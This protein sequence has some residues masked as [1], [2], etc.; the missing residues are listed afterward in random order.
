MRIEGFE[1]PRGKLTIVIGPTA[2]GKS[3]LVNAIMGEALVSADSAKVYRRG[4]IGFVPQEAWIMNAT[5]RDN[6]LMGKEHDA[7]A[8]KAAVVACQ[9]KSDL[10][11]L[12]GSDQTE[13][14]E[15]GINL[16]GGQKQRVAFARAVYSDSDIVIMDD[17]LSA[18]DPHVCGALF[19]ACIRTALAGKTRVLV[20]HQQ[21]FLEWADQVVVVAERRVVFRG[22]Y[23]DLQRDEA[24]QDYVAASA[25]AQPT[26]EELPQRSTSQ[27]RR[28]STARMKRR[29][30]ATMGAHEATLETSESGSLFPPAIDVDEL[31][32]VLTHMDSHTK[33]PKSDRTPHRHGGSSTQ[34]GFPP[35]LSP[36]VVSTIGVTPS[37]LDL[38]GNMMLDS[39]EELG[40]ALA[41]AVDGWEVPAPRPAE[42]GAT[43]TPGMMQAEKQDLSAIGW[44]I[45][46]WYCGQS[47]W[48]V[49]V[50]A[51]VIYILWR[52]TSLFA[53]LYLSWWATRTP[54]FGRF[55]HTGDEYLQWYGILVAVTGVF[56]V[57]RMFP[58][59]QG[60]INA[61]QHAHSRMVTSL[62]RS[63]MSFF[64]TTPTGRI[65]NRCSKD[66][67]ML[68][69]VVPETLSI[70]YN[71]V[72]V[73]I[74][75]WILQTVGAWPMPIVYAIV[76]TLFIYFFRGYVVTNHG[77]KRLDAVLR[78]PVL[79][80][81][82]EALGGLPTIRAY[83]MADSYRVTHSERL[84]DMNKSSYAWR[85]LQRWLGWRTDLLN[86]VVIGA[87]GMIAI[88]LLSVLSAEDRR[89]FYPIAALGITYAIVV[90]S[91]VGFL[92]T[93]LAEL[94]AAFS[95]VERVR[96]YADE[97]QQERDVTYVAAGGSG[98]AVRREEGT[99]LPLEAPAP[100]AGWPS[101]GAVRFDNVFL[102]YRAGL[103]LV[104]RGVSFDVRAGEKVGI[105]GRT[106]S[107]KS[108]IMLALFRMIETDKTVTHTEAGRLE[109]GA[110]AEVG[111]GV[112]V[113]AT[114][115]IV[116][117]GVDIAAL[118][119]Q[120]LRENITIIP[121]DPLLFAGTIRSNLDPFDQ[122]GD[123]A[124]WEVLGKAHVR[125]R[126]E[127][128]EL[129]LD[130]P[131]ADR[132]G[133]FSA[134]ERQLLCLARAL[135]KD[136]KVLL[137][138]E[139]TASIDPHHDQLLQQTIRREFADRTVL[140]IA[141]R[142]GTII[143]SDKVLVLDAGRVL[144]YGQPHE[145]LQHV[146]NAEGED[147]GAFWGMVRELGE[148]EAAR[149][150]AIAKQKAQQASL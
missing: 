112:G 72:L 97:L 15:R 80:I 105:V 140:T 131:V 110:L 121:Q 83:T 122:H 86:A 58:L 75:A 98:E 106:G 52:A 114:N 92:T 22:S 120:D 148:E 20:T 96:E 27:L 130:C 42:D 61:S 100:P 144:E 4:S 146:G 23:A 94:I 104:L 49:V 101:A 89:E 128:E 76:V 1:I 33:T 21:Q 7:D 127:S 129:Q 117:D 67:E 73:V 24:A 29:M 124:I 57:L 111:A 26:D 8:Y 88:G 102:R 16:S 65:L 41:T 142:L 34:R 46:S 107:G 30:T 135:L 115:R 3:T 62:L 36:T 108:T 44:P 51:W 118:R 31:P 113:D 141:H 9:L 35:V 74:G 70:F 47:G 138:D 25:K 90:T 63:P 78:S 68:D 53:D 137:M 123:A 143:D 139:A 45:F 50:L 136:C 18:V 59:V 48:G 71:L 84:H 109:G 126:V 132:G 134:G 147:G 149:L 55:E 2:G 95:S 145:L 10:E 28:Q 32:E 119:A 125:A 81:M 99:L 69:V 150:A 38:G 40:A 133:N 13:I 87:V 56:V 6:I 11:Q 37:D 39:F 103:D 5:L 85:N 79:S 64:D 116:V 77:V 12:P 14:G 54:A 66:L 43:G 91:A 82:N 93:M 17:P 19:H 60:M